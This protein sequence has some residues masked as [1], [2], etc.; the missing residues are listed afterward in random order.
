MTTITLPPDVEGPL[1]EAAS[2]QGTSPEL[3]AIDS[4]RKLFV[5]G[6]PG[7]APAADTARSL[8]EFLSGHIGV[9]S[10]AEFGSAGGT[11]SGK[12]GHDFAAGLALKKRQ[13]R[14]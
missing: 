10:S 8:C 11:M 12:S 7:C 1:S 14:L 13:G 2:N 5:A 6:S 3:L 4:L 9:I